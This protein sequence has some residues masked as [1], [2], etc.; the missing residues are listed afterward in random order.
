MLLNDPGI[1]SREGYIAS[2]IVG[3]PMALM[4]RI[5]LMM[6]ALSVGFLTAI[7]E[8]GGVIAVAI[9]SS[10]LRIHPCAAQMKEILKF[11]EAA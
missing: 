10:L 2:A 7:F 1:E 6:V 8:A 11:N 4:K 9:V 5:W 3:W